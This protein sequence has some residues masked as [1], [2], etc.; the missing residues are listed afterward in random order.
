MWQN[1]QNLHTRKLN[2]QNLHT[3]KLRALNEISDNFTSTENEFQLISLQ[4][5][6]ICNFHIGK[7]A[8]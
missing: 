6:L 4:Y 8:V 1:D 7:N 5:H 2:D 3:R